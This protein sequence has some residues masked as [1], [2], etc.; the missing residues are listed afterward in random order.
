MK[1]P[2]KRERQQITFNHLLDID[3]RDFTNFYK[4]CT[5][6]PYSF[7]VIDTTLTSDLSSYFRTNLLERI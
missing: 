3:F 6:R 2:N 4:K 7:L 1:I 5:A